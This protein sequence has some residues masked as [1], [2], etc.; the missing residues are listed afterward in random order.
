MGF[1]SVEAVPAIESTAEGPCRPRIRHVGLA[2]RAQV[3]L[4]DGV[5]GESVCPK[6]LRDETVL[7][8]RTAPVARESRCQVGHPAHAAAMVVSPRQEAGPRGRAQ[9][10]G[11]EVGQSHAFGCDRID[12]GGLDVGPIAAQLGKSDVVEHDEHHVGRSVG[13]SGQRRPPSLG[14][15]PVVA[16]LSLKL[17]WWHAH[18]LPARPC[19]KRRTRLACSF[20][21]SLRI[22]SS[23]RT[24]EAT[25]VQVTGAPPASSPSRRGMRPEGCSTSGCCLP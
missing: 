11:V 14:V 15:A 18:I 7:A 4:P 21:L 13:R 8:G 12:E 25:S 17:D 19:S 16:D 3:P 9:G 23:M 5:G 24:S 10:G 2:L 20:S 22:I 1:P 6:H